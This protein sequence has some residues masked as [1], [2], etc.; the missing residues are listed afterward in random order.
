MQSK[1]YT[2]VNSLII[3]SKPRKLCFLGNPN[4]PLKQ[5]VPKKETY[6]NLLLMALQQIKWMTVV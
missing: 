3:Y 1:I 2:D 6:F 4:L 5:F